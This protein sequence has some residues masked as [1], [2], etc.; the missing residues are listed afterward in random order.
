LTVNEIPGSSDGQVDEVVPEQAGQRQV[1]IGVFVIAGLIATIYL[2]YLLTDPAT[3]RNRY[4]ITTT[5]E[6]VMGL[7]KGDPVQMRGVNIGQVND[8][9]M[10]TEGENVVIILEVEGQWLIPEGSRTQL[11]SPGIMAPRTVEVVPGP[12]PGTIGAGDALP[13]STVKGLLD[14]TESLGEKGQLVLDRIAELLSPE[15][16]EAISG[17]TDGL[18]TLVGELSDVIE[19]ESDNLSELIQSFNRAADGLAEITGDGAELGEDLASAMAKADSVMDRL[20]ATSE[21][22]NEAAASLQTILTR[23]EN[24]EGTLGQL[25]VN[26][27]LFTNL[28][29]A[30][31]SARLLMDDLR[32]NPGRYINVS[33]F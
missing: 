31:E 9:E 4:K 17:S 7:R 19:S 3:F 23:V 18:N 21:R 28:T 20:N 10:G 22:V 6:N 13:G 29:T 11:V 26:D 24:G 12:G 16:L 8:F 32:E 14:D 33:I 5:V 2:L 1:R 30:V 25:S 15:N 27:S